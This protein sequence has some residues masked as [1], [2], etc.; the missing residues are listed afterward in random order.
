ML[1]Y[2]SSDL[3]ASLPIQHNKLTLCARVAAV[4][5]S[6]LDKWRHLLNFCIDD[7]SR[8]CSKY[9]WWGR[10]GSPSSFCGP[11][12]SYPELGLAVSLGSG[13]LV[14]LK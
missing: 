4:A 7:P 5:T 14:T 2:G 9:K 11:I 6:R 1:H 8:Q 10:L 13:G 3:V 12:N